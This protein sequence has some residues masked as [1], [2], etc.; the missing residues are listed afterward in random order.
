MENNGREGLGRFVGRI[1]LPF[2]HLDRVV[3][4]EQNLQLLLLQEIPRVD[5]PYGG[6]LR[7]LSPE[8]PGYIDWTNVIYGIEE[9][10][11]GICGEDTGKR[12]ELRVWEAKIRGVEVA[13]DDGG[14][15]GVKGSWKLSNRRVKVL[16][17]DVALAVMQLCGNDHYVI[18]AR[19]LAFLVLIVHLVEG[20]S[21]WKDVR[22]S[23]TVTQTTITSYWKSQRNWM[24][25]QDLVMD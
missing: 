4:T 9:Q 16:K 7:L 20:F 23:K 5:S 15:S 10:G 14:H 19:A 21:F 22:E 24:D 12:E 2:C 13:V 3:G 11:R 25:K 17:A 8:G 6:I 18:E 1:G